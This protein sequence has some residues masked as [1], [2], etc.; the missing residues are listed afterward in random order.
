MIYSI[1][2][3]LWSGNVLIK[4]FKQETLKNLKGCKKL[5]EIGAAKAGKR[6]PFI[7]IF[8]NTAAKAEID[9]PILA[10]GNHKF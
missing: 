8:V 1:I 2:S 4:A 6:G 5:K 10:N 7:H 9:K 3:W